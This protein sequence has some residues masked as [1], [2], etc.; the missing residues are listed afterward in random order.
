[1]NDTFDRLI[2]RRNTGSCKWESAPSE[3]VNNGCFPM[4]VADMEFAIAEPIQRALKDAVSHAICGYTEVDD[5]YFN[6]LSSFMKRR[7]NFEVKRE[8]LICTSGVVPA[9]GII[10][11]ALTNP[12]DGII[13][14]PPV[15]TPFF[16]AIKLNGRN[17]LENPLVVKDGHYEINFDQL[18]ELCKNG[19]KMLM[20]CSPHNPVGRTWTRDE[21]MQVGEICKKH[22]VVILCDE[23]HNDIVYKGSDHTVLATLPGMR[24][25]TIT[26]TAMSKTFNLAGLML[27]NIFIFNKEMYDKVNRRIDIDSSRCIPYFGR[28]ASI[29]AFSECDEWLDSLLVYLSEN[30]KFC[31]NF[32][33]N[34]IPEM[35]CT[36]A[37]STYL[38]WLDCR[39]LGLS[40]DDLTEFFAKRAKTPVNSGASFGTG[41][42]GFVR[43][44]IALPRKE[45]ENA[46]HRISDAVDKYIRR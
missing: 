18:D 4:T 9:F 5:A 17:I 8:N 19:A 11:R 31:Y 30:F 45:L 33:E 1:M 35:K 15:Y 16:N 21:L 13:V 44:N 23:I 27:S 14:Q 22:S 12:D 6:A 26:C 34:N 7:H 28:A 20:L 46:L 43:L 24:D 37:D 25:I 10:I 36:K 32:I 42:S 41:G 2:D 39:A 40:D 3:C 38:L 29:A